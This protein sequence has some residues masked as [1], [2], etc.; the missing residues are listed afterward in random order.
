MSNKFKGS[1]TEQNLINAFA[2]ESQARNRYTYFA[3]VA[4]KEGW[5]MLSYFINISVQI[6]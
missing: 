1:R 5:N 4:K 3:K 2:G 6:R